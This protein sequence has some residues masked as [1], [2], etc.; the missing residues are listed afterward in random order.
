NV[1]ACTYDETENGQSIKMYMGRK[2]YQ[3]PK[4]AQQ[5]ELEFNTGITAD[6]VSWVTLTADEGPFDT[7]DYYIG[8]F[9]IDAENGAY[10]QLLS[11]QKVGKAAGGAADLYFATLGASKFGFSVVG[12]HKDGSP[13]YSKGAQAALERN[14]VRY[15][16][17]L[18]AYMQTHELDGIDGLRKR[19]AL[20]YDATE[21]YA[22]QLHEV[23]RDDYLR[24]KEKE[25]RHQV[26]LQARVNGK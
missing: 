10:A 17:A 15:L 25:H 13:K 12:T 18:R 5:I 11:S 9:A 4:K 3:N 8:L 16:L 1:K 24:D 2:F 20:W 26:E 23:D 19:A 7:S 14:V 6:G 22:E 21:N